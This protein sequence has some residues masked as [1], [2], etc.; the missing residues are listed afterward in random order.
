[1]MSA[2]P[3]PPMPSD[4]K[5]EF[6]GGVMG[7]VGNTGG[8]HLAP[9]GNGQLWFRKKVGPQLQDER[10]AIIQTGWPALIS[11]GVYTRRSMAASNEVRSINYQLEGGWLWAGA[12]LPMA[13]K[14]GD[15]T[16]LTTQPGIRMSFVGLVQLPVGFSWE[17]N[18]NMRL[19]AEIGG[20][21]L[22]FNHEGDVRTSLWMAYG[23]LAISSSR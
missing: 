19:D 11:G 6:G 16:W 2:P 21:A 13:V 10:G 18:N 20:R 14:V 7:A 8:P 1:M 4:A 12:S 15:N 17:L 9:F 23:A 5:Q 3:S 22:G